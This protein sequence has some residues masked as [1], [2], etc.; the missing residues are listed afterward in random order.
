MVGNNGLGPIRVV[1]FLISYMY[2]ETEANIATQ[3][4]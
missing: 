3:I 2:F 4:S 1:H